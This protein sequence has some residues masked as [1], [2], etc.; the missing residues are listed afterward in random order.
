MKTQ[1]EIVAEIEKVSASG[2]D[3]FGARRDE[4]IVALDFEHAKAYILDDVTEE[5]WAEHYAYK[6]DEDV[7]KGAIDYLDFAVGKALNHRGIS[8]GRSVDHFLGFAFLIGGDEAVQ[9]IQ[10]TEY[11]NYG[12][13]QLDQATELLGI[14]EAWVTYADPRSEDGAQ[15]MNMAAGRPCRRGCESGCAA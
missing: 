13:P 14:R 9:A 6:T 10:N 15:L 2:E 11:Q 4:L 5:Q 1:D 3:M 7:R 8:A 12:V